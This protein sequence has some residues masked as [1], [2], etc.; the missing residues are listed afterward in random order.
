[1]GGQIASGGWMGG[2]IATLSLAT[3]VVSVFAGAAVA[4]CL[5]ARNDSGGGTIA[6]E[7]RAGAASAVTNR[8]RVKQFFFIGANSNAPGT[9]CF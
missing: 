1:M 5:E 7:R 6:S 8:T 2:Q 4:L 3:T 9:R